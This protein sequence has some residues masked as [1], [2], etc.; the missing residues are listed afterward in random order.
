[1]SIQ[2]KTN[3]RQKITTDD[4]N[5]R[6]YHEE[7]KCKGCDCWIDVDEV[8]WA[9]ADGKLN[10]REGD[11]YCDACLPEEVMTDGI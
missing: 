1:M 2:V 6:I 7:W 8:I 5:P 3:G 10:T 4:M 11:P 9:T